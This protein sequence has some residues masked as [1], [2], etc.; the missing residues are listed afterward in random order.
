MTER[1]ANRYEYMTDEEL[2]DAA[3]EHMLQAEIHEL[4]A[5]RI[6]EELKRR[7]QTAVMGEPLCLED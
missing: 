6:A 3:S 2:L 7:R 4:E 5:E 1:I